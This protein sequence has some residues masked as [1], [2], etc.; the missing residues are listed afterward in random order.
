MNY[1]KK[2]KELDFY[3]NIN[4]EDPKKMKRFQYIID[5]VKLLIDDAIEEKDI[6]GAYMSL[7]QLHRRLSK[8]NDETYWTMK[9]VKK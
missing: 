7:Y 1:R 6:D 4:L 9:E 3:N 8:F 5:I 2:I